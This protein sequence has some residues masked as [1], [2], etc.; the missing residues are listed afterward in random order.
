LWPYLQDNDAGWYVVPG[1]DFSLLCTD[2]SLCPLDQGHAILPASEEQQADALGFNV[3]WT[4]SDVGPVRVEVVQLLQWTE[5]RPEFFVTVQLDEGDEVGLYPSKSTSSKGQLVLLEGEL[6]APDTDTHRL[7]FR[8]RASHSP[9][10]SD[11]LE[12]LRA[13]VVRVDQDDAIN[14]LEPVEPFAWRDPAR[15]DSSSAKEALVVS[16]NADYRLSHLADGMAFQWRPGGSPVG[17]DAAP[18]KV[19]WDHVCAAFDERD[20]PCLTVQWGNDQWVPDLPASHQGA[21][22]DLVPHSEGL[23]LF[24]HE[25]SLTD[26]TDDADGVLV[27]PDLG[28]FALLE[29]PEDADYEVF[30]YWPK[31]TRGVPGYTRRYLAVAP[32]SGEYTLSWSGTATHSSRF[33]A[34][35]ERIA[36]DG[37]VTEVIE[38]GVSE[39]NEDA[40]AFEAEEAEGLRIVFE[41]IQSVGSTEARLEARISSPEDCGGLPL[42]EWTRSTHVSEN[43]AAYYRCYSAW[44]TADSYEDMDLEALCG[45]E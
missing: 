28:I 42:S 21:L 20:G 35:L 4:P 2:T 1:A 45:S 13:L 8:W 44:F 11:H 14:E 24:R 19:L 17:Y 9:V 15:T 10:G 33:N 3:M 22:L 12:R 39:A 32:C 34:R 29:P 41:E 7:T 30:A 25:L 37:T 16:T 18:A 5:L 31:Y 26:A 27:P 36:T 23:L 38:V 40:Y 43:Q 6:D